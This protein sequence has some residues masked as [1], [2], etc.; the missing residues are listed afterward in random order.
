M[1]RRDM[2][3]YGVF[4]WLVGIKVEE[5]RFP[6]SFFLFVLFFSFFLFCFVLVDW[7]SSNY[8]ENKLCM[9]YLY[10]VYLC[11]Y[12]YTFIIIKVDMNGSTMSCKLVLLI[13]CIQYKMM[14]GHEFVLKSIF[15]NH[16]IEK[17]THPVL[18]L[19]TCTRTWTT[20]NYIPRKLHPQIRH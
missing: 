5:G 4:C 3:V 9:I 6:T 16:D 20:T 8:R 14:P 10:I 12:V 1:Q 11:V 2:Y 17:T 19:G 15:R 18:Q 7:C 13:H